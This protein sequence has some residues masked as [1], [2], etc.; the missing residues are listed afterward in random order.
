MAVNFSLYR[1]DE[2]R[3]HRFNP[4]TKIALVFALMAIAFL[5]ASTW[6]P[7]ALVG[8]VVVPAAFWGGFGT[9][10]LKTIVRIV[11]PLSI[12]I[13]GLQFLFYP[14]AE[15][16]LFEALGLSG[17]LEGI[18]FGLRIVGRLAVLV[19]SFLVLM[20]STHPSV[21]MTDLARRG[22][23]G[24]FPYLITST[25]QIVPQMQAKAATIIDAQRARGLE[26]Q[27][28]L[29]RRARALVPLLGP[30]VLGSLSDVHERTIAIEA[31]AFTAPG[32][33]TALHEVPGSPREAVVRWAA[34]VI[35]VGMGVSFLW[36]SFN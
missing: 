20:F 16:V 18:G 3:L 27:G 23:P 4:T 19:S 36:R 26:T 14:E 8:G 6:I 35:I 32:T 11:L 25:L 31:R 28:S 9:P 33:K 13:V 17:S 2:G 24:V 34:L 30:L 5:S 21:L 10:L 12:F 7:W 22:V 29:W 1:E 15:T